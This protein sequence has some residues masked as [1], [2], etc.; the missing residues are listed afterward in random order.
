MS[1]FDKVLDV[2]YDVKFKVE[3]TVDNFK[4]KLYDVIHGVHIVSDEELI[5]ASKKASK[6]KAKSKKKKK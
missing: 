4:F 3:D 1:L 5:K 2:Y 6:K